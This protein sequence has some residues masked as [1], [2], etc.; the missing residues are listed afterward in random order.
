MCI[1]FM[2]IASKASN[3]GDYSLI[4]ASNRDE[5]YDRPSTKM[6]Q[7]EEDLNVYGGRD[8][9]DG[10]EGGTWLA[11]SPIRKKL[12]VLLNIP[13][14][15]K[16]DPKSRGVLVADYV[17][18]ELSTKE[19][20]DKM[21]SYI[22]ECS[23]FLFTTVEFGATTSVRSYDNISKTLI[24]HDDPILGFSNSLP[25]QP[26]QKVE[27]G[28]DALKEICEKYNKIEQ[29]EQLINEL[30]N[31][32]LKSK[33]KHLP[34]PLLETRKPELYKEFSS[35]YVFLPQARYGTRTHTLILLTKT[36]HLEVIEKTMVRPIETH[37]P[38]WETT[39][40]QFDL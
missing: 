16:D 18:S 36:G 32:L 37:N 26:L 19:Y 15:A 1:L 30:L 35:I 9:Q 13:G 40:Y 14:A 6:V 7:W 29:K 5:Y 34:D 28:K 39:E 20:I 21:S 10:C 11:I 8:M 27:P 17:K 33:K 23:G 2:Y 31:T 22:E 4:L 38:E 25:E 3:D 24:E 12:G